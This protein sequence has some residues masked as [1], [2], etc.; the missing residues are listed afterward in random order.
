[1]EGH[2]SPW[3]VDVAHALEPL[4]P[5]FL[6]LALG[7]FPAAAAGFDWDTWAKV[8]N[9]NPCQWLDAA[10]V[11]ELLGTSSPG[12]ATTQRNETRCQWTDAAGRP[13]FTAAVLTWD[14][15]A[16]LTGERK[17]QVKE[18]ESGGKRFRFVGGK[19]GVVTAVLRTDKVKLMLFPNSDQE[20]AV[21]VLSG[22]PVLREGLDVLKQKNQ[23]AERFA[24]A[25]S[26]KFGLQ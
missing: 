22:H 4:R 18:A 1:M 25:L 17:A 12:K 10:T 16:N 14:S 23:R 9:E 5:L 20:T 15:A 24:Q 6:T 8:V 21:I 26:A 2:P 7:A 3:R 13:V 19:D 11:T